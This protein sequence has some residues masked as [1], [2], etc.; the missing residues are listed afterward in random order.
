M[1]IFGTALVLGGGGVTGIAWETGLIAGLAEAGLDL[2]RAETVVGTSA[3]SVVGAQITS[4]EALENL[5]AEQLRDASDEV[6][7]ALGKGDLLRFGAYLLMPGDS[8]KKRARLGRA[9]IR[10]DTVDESVRVEVIRERIGERPWPQR[11][12]LVTAVNARTGE[13]Q[14][15]D[16]ES[17][18]DLVHAVASSCAVPLVWPPVSVNGDRY[19]DGGM[20]SPA[21][22]DLAN[23]ARHVVALAPI[24]TAFSRTGRVQTQLDRLGSGVASLLICPDAQSKRAIGSNV[25]D[26]AKRAAS[27]RAGRRQAESVLE[28]VRAVWPA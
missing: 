10:A 24:P 28:R 13:F 18:V 7:A 25:L 17:G 26:P 6:A 20:R 21:N 11:R 8:R 3:G 2:T 16:R 22:A 4:G 14:V 19:I 15:F 9:A 27:A 12:L 1:T 5:F 23:G